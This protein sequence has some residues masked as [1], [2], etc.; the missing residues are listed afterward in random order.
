MRSSKSICEVLGIALRLI[1]SVVEDK[2]LWSP[3][4]AKRPHLFRK[5]G[6]GLIPS[7]AFPLSFPA[8]SNTTKRI[9]NP[10]RIVSIGNHPL[11]LR[12]K[13]ALGIWIKR[14][15][16]DFTNQAILHPTNDPTVIRAGETNSGSCFSFRV[17]EATEDS[18]GLSRGSILSRNSQRR[19]A[20]R[21]KSGTKLEN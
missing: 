20:T 16:I 4:F 15:T 10:L 6:I 3:I 18:K 7:D 9:K 1:T 2:L 14:I 21:D 5:F 12:A 19:K 11:C 8:F 17:I 13:V